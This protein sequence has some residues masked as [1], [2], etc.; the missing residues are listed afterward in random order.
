MM[1]K[2]ATFRNMSTIWHNHISYKTEVE[3][4]FIIINFKQRV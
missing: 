2:Y 4:N 3:E 1:V